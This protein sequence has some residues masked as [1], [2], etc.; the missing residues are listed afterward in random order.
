MG[1]QNKKLND[2]LKK[3]KPPTSRQTASS[4]L[5]EIFLAH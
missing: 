3:K 4:S 5:K 1:I 2:F